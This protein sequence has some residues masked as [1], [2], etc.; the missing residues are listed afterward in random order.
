MTRLG[1]LAAALLALSTAAPPAHAGGE[2]AGDFDYYVL[3]LSWSPTWCALTGDARN[4]PQ[5]DPKHDHSFVLH[6]LWPQYERGWPS[7]CRTPHR[8]PS[9]Q[10]TA[11]MEDLTGAPGLAWYEWKKHGRCSGLSATDYFALEREAYAS[12]EIPDVLAN[13]DRDVKLPAKVVEQAFLEANPGLD[14]DEITIT[15]KSGRI[16]EAR[17]CLTKDLEPRKCG[18]DTIRDCSL[19][20]ALMEKVR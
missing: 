19:S 1:L 2:R 9:R 10:Q 17:I 4:S 12:I 8:D 13:L 16:Q 6:G 15:C 18:S 20:D 11:A 7:F 5:C 3:S 14:A